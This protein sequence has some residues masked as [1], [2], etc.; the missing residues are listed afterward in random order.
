MGGSR[1]DYRG[2]G[3]GGALDTG[4][5]QI[6]TILPSLVKGGLWA[7]DV[8]ADGRD[9]RPGLVGVGL[10]GGGAGRLEGLGRGG[11]RYRQDGVGPGCRGPTGAQAGL[12]VYMW[13]RLAELYESSHHPS[14]YI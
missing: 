8:V 12:K 3:W 14:T 1:W 4:P 13:H 6:L 2:R 5:W 11:G 7:K 10:T 9:S